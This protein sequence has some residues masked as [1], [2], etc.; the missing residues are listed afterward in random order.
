MVENFRPRGFHPRALAGSQ[1]D[2]MQRGH[3]FNPFSRGER[4]DYLPFFKGFFAN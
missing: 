4:G 3:R 1:D 2:D